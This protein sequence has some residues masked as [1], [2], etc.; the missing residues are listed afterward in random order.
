MTVSLEIAKKLI[1]K[2][3]MNTREIAKFLKRDYH[4]TNQAIMRMFAIDRIHI[5]KMRKNNFTYYKVF[6]TRYDK[7][8]RQIELWNLALFNKPIDSDNLS[9]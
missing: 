6:S 3:W 9:A 7:N 4:V 1:G 5:E 8:K 2:D